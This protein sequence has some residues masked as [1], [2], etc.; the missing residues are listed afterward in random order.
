MDRKEII[1]TVEKFINEN[2]AYTDDA[3]PEIDQSLL[4]TG[5]I[6]ST[7]AL[8]LVE[9]L[10]STFE[11]RIKENEMVTNN[12]DSIDRIASFVERKIGG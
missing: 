10:E 8:E 2:L 5:I 12:L 1:Q 7:G 4:Q 9:F 3:S 11:I 6:D